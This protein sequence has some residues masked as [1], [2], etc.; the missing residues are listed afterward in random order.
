M[1]LLTAPSVKTIKFY[2]LKE[3][4]LGAV[5]DI[6]SAIDPPAGLGSYSN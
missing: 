1:Y 4:S 6:S 5:M 3:T 2:D